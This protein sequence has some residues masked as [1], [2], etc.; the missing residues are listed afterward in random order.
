MAR[1]ST[2]LSLDADL[3]AEARLL[4]V[5]ISRSAESGLRNA[6]RDAR[7]AAWREENRDA[8]DAYGTEIDQAGLP[9]ESYRLF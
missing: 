5:N 3:L 7:I 4:G 9:L 1:R 2:S 6:V 8:L